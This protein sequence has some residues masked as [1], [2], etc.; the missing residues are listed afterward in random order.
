MRQGTS[1][2]V[3]RRLRHGEMNRKVKLERRRTVEKAL[4]KVRAA[5][6]VPHLPRVSLVMRDRVTGD[7]GD[8]ER[9]FGCGSA[10]NL[11]KDLT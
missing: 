3:F 1:I 4:I 7:R 2:W 5:A 9:V 10:F 11:F 6:K 8:S